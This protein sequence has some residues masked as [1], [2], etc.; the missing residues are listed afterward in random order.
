MLKLAFCINNS[1]IF[2]KQ[3]TIDINSVQYNSYY[4]YFR[5]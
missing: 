2:R 4:I 3:M 1:V 5:L